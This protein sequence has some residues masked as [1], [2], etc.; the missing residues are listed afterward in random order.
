MK[1]PNIRRPIHGWIPQVLI[2]LLAIPPRLGAQQPAPPQEAKPAASLAVVQSLK[3]T[4]LAG[5]GEFNDLA[6]RVMAPLVIQ[7]LDQNARPIEGAD[8]IFRFPLTGPSATFPNQ[9]N[10]QTVRT[11]ADGQAAAVGWTATGGVGTFRVQVTASR[12]NE[13]GQT[14][15]T[16]TNVTQIVNDGKA[17]KKHWWSSKWGKIGIIAGSAAVVAAVVLTTRSGGSSSTTTITAVP[18]FP[19]IGGTQ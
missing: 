18:G 7:V 6:R 16:M 3:I 2:V 5:E 12:G 13:Q 14:S 11:N 9:R 17:K 10:S 8:V 15:V 1:P 19:T 4:P